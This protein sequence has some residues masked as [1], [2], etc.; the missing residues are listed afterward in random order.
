MRRMITT[1]LVAAA[2]LAIS[3]P[4]EA[5]RWGGGPGHGPGPGPG[6]RGGGM[7]GVGHCGRM[8][9]R[10]PPQEL[11]AKL[12]LDDKQLAR[13]TALRDNLANKQIDLRAKL[14]KN[15]LKLRKLM[16]ADLPDQH[17]VLAEMRRMRG[18]RGVLTEESVKAYLRFLAVLT[19]EQRK[20]VREMCS[21]RGRGFG[22]H[23]R[24]D[25]RGR[26]GGHGRGGGPGWGPPPPPPP[27]A[28]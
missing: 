19:A 4:A 10:V 11:K 5:R 21:H 6:M 13:A 16:E 12:K 8:L 24:H 26:G 25:R 15:K 7:S 20:Q 2:V 1:S 18:T 27:A 28:P 9:M 17:K 22:K 3:G 23:W 14:A